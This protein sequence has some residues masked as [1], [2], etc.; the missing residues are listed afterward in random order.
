MR[1][2]LH[3]ALVVAIVP[4]LLAGCF[5]SK[6]LKTLEAE[7]SQKPQQVTALENI[8]K[9]DSEQA[10]KEYSEFLKKEADFNKPLKYYQSQLRIQLHQ[11]GTSNV[12][13]LGDDVL[14]GFPIYFHMRLGALVK[15]QLGLARLHLARNDL[16][17]AE[18]NA[19]EAMDIINR[20]ARSNL[21]MAREGLSVHKQLGT[22]Y[23]RN[24]SYGKALLAK[25][26]EELLEDFLRS[27]YVSEKIAGHKEA[28]ERTHDQIQEIDKFV[29]KVNRR[30]TAKA[31]AELASAVSQVAGGLDIGDTALTTTKV[32]S[33][34]MGIVTPTLTASLDSPSGQGIEKSLSPLANRI[35]IS[36]LLDPKMGNNPERIIKN[37]ISTAVRVKGTEKV[38]GAAEEVLAGVDALLAARD[39]SDAERMSAI[40]KFA[41]AF[42]AL[43]YQVQDFHVTIQ[44]SGKL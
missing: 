11:M 4:L 33:F 16:T 38:R 7:I 28:T 42:T 14:A 10:F 2:Y 43:Q 31:I 36:Q 35:L 21:F 15:A 26:N 40:K 34:S 19:K 3:H 23:E 27:E 9:T 37:F 39:Q 25:L 30:R 18:K 41:E 13:V 32:L 22:I 6:S 8:E 12:Q 17:E 44:S 20:R 24:G 1:T 29:S 5:T